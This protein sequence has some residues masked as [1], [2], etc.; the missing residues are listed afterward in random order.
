MI[1]LVESS[2]SSD[3]LI[4][5]TD[6]SY[7][8]EKGGASAAVNMED[9][10]TL[11]AALGFNTHYSNHK[12][13][14]VGVLLAM[15]LI[16]T[17]QQRKKREEALILTDNKGVLQQLTNCDAAKPGQYIFI[18]IAKIWQELQHETKLTFV[19]CPGH[20]GI[21]GNETADRIAKEATDRNPDPDCTMKANLTKITRSLG[22]QLFKTNKKTLAQRASPLHISYSALINQLTAEHSPL[23]HYL[24]KSKRRLDPICPFCPGKET[25]HHLFDF[26]AKYRTAQRTLLTQARKKKIQCDWNQPHQLLKSPKAHP[27][28]AD[29]LK[30]TG[31]FAYL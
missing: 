10:Y 2:N 31:R 5:Y 30:S 21:P 29:F 24:F 22:S 11:S 7:D 3:T 6:G 26:C 18:E 25:T 4:V 8:Q 19:W 28:I 15:R 23:H 20:Q 9:N 13:E 1:S 16:Q 12:C 27:L 14:A 17:L